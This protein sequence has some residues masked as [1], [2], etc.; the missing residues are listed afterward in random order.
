MLAV[1]SPQT[2]SAGSPA[3]QFL[4]LGA[5]M[6]ASGLIVLVSGLQFDLESLLITA[7]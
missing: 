3:L 5:T 1:L 4:I 7:L 6:K 2:A